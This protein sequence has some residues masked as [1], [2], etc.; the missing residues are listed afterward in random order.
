MPR[1]F[2]GGVGEYLDEVAPERREETIEGI[3]SRAEELIEADADTVVDDPSQGALGICAVV[4][5]SYEVLL[6][7]FG[8]DKC[9]R[10]RPDLF[11]M[12]VHRCFFREFFV[13]HEV[14]LLTTVMCAV[15][16]QLDAGDR[17]VGQRPPR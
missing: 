12:K 14:P 8:G 11:E 4:L 1:Q 13:R 10:P 7:T 9:A 15:R 17:T 6:P 2:L 5:G 3:R 16:R